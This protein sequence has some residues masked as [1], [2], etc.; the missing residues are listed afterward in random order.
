[1]RK[2][3]PVLTLALSSILA[4]SPELDQALKLYQATDY[5]AAVQ[6]LEKSQVKDAPTWELLGRAHYMA[7]DFKKATEC[8]EK[9]VIASPSNSEYQHWLGRAYGRRAETSS[10]LNALPLARKTRDSFE[11]AVALNPS[12]VE[13]INDLFEFYL[14]APGFLG[15]GLEK[16]SALAEKIKNLDEVEYHYTSAK[17]AE[18]RKQFGTAEDHL[19]RAS[20]LAPKQVGR[21]LDLASFLAKQGKVQESDAAL[22]RAIKI[23]PN[24]P[25]VVFEQARILVEGKR[26][27]P[28]AR[29]LLKQYLSSRLSPDDPPRAEAEKLLRQAQGS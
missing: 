11:R 13:A 3:L 26:N 4:A 17:L 19:R 23:A 10:W 6:V 18:K 22:A 27:L 14:E 5:K 15:G 25:K 2:L 24:S 20:E 1:M 21:I 16:A 29:K 7:G 28:E 9:A 8:L 12:N